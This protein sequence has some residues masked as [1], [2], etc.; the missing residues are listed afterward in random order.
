MSYK[1][2]PI[3]A[4]LTPELIEAAAIKAATT[5]GSL[6]DR[7]ISFRAHQT[8]RKIQAKCPGWDNWTTEP[9][10]WYKAYTL[11]LVAEE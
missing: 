6:P 1:D 4:V 11:G 5:P 8:L 7:V 10:I 3:G 9:E 2:W